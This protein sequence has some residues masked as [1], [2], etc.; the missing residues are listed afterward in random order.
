[1]GSGAGGDVAFE[2]ESAGRRVRLESL[3]REKQILPQFLDTNRH[4][5]QLDQFTAKLKEPPA[6]S[7]DPR[8]GILQANGFQKRK[9]EEDF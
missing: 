2:P 6:F 3:S 9:G 8:A 7:F 1:M 4:I 5:L